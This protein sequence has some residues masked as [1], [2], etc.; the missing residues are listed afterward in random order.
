MPFYIRQK[1]FLKNCFKIYYCA[2]IAI[3]IESAKWFRF[4]HYKKG[5]KTIFM[6]ALI[7]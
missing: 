5:E 7:A 3:K 4:G 6:I 1:L 2:K